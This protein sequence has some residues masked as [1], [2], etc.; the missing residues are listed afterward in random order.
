MSKALTSMSKKELIAE[1]ERIRE[2][3]KQLEANQIVLETKAKK[4]PKALKQ[5]LWVCTCGTGNTGHGNVDGMLQGTNHPLTKKGA[6]RKLE[7]FDDKKSKNF[8]KYHE[9]TFLD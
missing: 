5:I 6:Q 9:V 3:N 8:G 2:V 7:G 4:A 1:V